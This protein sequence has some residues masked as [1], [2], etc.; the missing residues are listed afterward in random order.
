MNYFVK[1]YFFELIHA[2]V[3]YFYIKAIA[4]YIL[5]Q[6]DS[7]DSKTMVNNRAYYEQMDSKHLYTIKNKIKKQI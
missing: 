6:V 7:L 5:Y 2:L 1:Y 3:L 4:D